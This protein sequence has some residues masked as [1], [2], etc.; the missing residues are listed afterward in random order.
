MQLEE[1]Q[2]TRDPRTVGALRQKEWWFSNL[3]DTDAGLY[4]SW[5]F[6][7][8]FAVDKFR[9]WL[10]DLSSQQTHT[11]DHTL[12]LERAQAP[13]ALDLRH[14]G[15]V[16][17]EYR[18]LSD[19]RAVFRCRSGDLR[20]DLE[21]ERSPHPFVRRDRYFRCNYNLLHHFFNHV[22]GE[23]EL[24]GRSFTIDTTRAYYDHCFGVVP[25]RASWQ[26]LAVQNHEL[27]IASLVNHGPY[28]QRYTQVFHAGA[29]HRLDPDVDFDYDAADLSAPWRVRSRELD[30]VVTPHRVHRDRIA[31][32]PLLPFLV[33]VQ[34]N[35]LFVAVAGTL[36]LHGA[37]IPVR[38]LSG[39]VEEHDG[40]W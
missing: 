11:V 25:R 37:R 27:A 13:G 8:A 39:V 28:A 36:T 34:H 26:W 3:H 4:M 35:E 12:Y 5:S 24:A 10:C 15:A 9:L 18:G 2:L 16:D 14:R 1:K 38:G 7:R 20:V 19:D 33:D 30:L 17:L 29:W 6:A 31:I 21:I 23:V 40:R 32:P 22:R